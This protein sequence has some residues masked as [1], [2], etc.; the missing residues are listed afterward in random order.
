MKYFVISG[1]FLGLLIA[2]FYIYWNKVQS[3]KRLD[4]NRVTQKKKIP[5]NPLVIEVMRARK[6][7]GS[8]IKVEETLAAGSNYNQYIVSYLSDGLKIHALLT[9]PTGNKPTM[10]WPAI[11]FNHGYIP[12][13]QYQTNERYVAYVDAFARNGYVVFKPD[14]R[15]HGQSEGQPEGAYYSPAYAIDVLNAVSSIKKYKDV[16]PNKIGMWGHSLGGNLT[17]RSMVI[18]KD[19]KV[20]VIWAGVVGTYEEL[21]NK[22]T[23]TTPWQP[24]PREAASHVRSIR[25]HLVETYGT[26]EKN[27]EFWQ[28]I[29]PRYFIK[30][31]SGPLQLHQGTADDEVPTLFSES[32]SNDLKKAGKTVEYFTYPGADHN[33]FQSF[34]LAMDRSVAFFDKYLK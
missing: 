24:S 18:S 9:I 1:I 21:M 32:L 23:R 5:Q 33:L 28:S 19:I 29:D 25:S 8:E 20:G 2:S 27:P 3:I 22:W 7:P 14:Y 4:P 6:Y 10:G 16:N 11:V 17:L 30:D 31:I 34:T 13:D 26:P 12:P 15:G